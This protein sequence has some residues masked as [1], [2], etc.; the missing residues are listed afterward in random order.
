M[1]PTIKEAIEYGEELAAI[2][3]GKYKKTLNL[4]LTA[5]KAYDRLM[6]EGVLEGIIL[7]S[8]EEDMMTCIP[9][10]DAERIAA[11]IRRKGVGSE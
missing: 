9:I 6:S 3:V 11:A 8:A 2:G 5:A 7:K 4:L 1:E 10:P